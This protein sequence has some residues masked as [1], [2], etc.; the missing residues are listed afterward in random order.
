M[1]SAGLV[2]NPVG[3]NSMFY[4]YVLKSVKDGKMYTGA[5]SN[6]RERFKEHLNG[7]TASTKGRGP[8]KLIYY[9]ACEAKQDA[10]ARERYLKFGFG[11]RYLKNRLKRSLT[12][13]GFST[14]EVVI[15]MAIL[16]TILSAVMVVSWGNQTALADSR[17]QGEAL[18]RAQGILEC[19][20]AQA[21][22]DFKLVSANNLKQN[23]PELVADTFYTKTVDVTQADIEDYFGMIKQVTATVGWPAENNRNLN[24]KLSTLVA[25][26]ENVIGGDTCSSVLLGNWNN[27]YVSNSETDLGNLVGDSTGLYPITDLEVYKNSLFLTINN[28]A[29]NTAETFFAFDVTDPTNPTLLSKIDN[30]ASHSAGLAAVASDGQFAFVASARSIPGS[31][32]PTFGQLQ[33]INVSV[34]PVQL[35]R[36]FAIASVGGT[37]G[38]GI[39]KSIYYKDGYVYLGLTKTGSGPEFNIIDV[40]DPLNPFWVGGYSVG[41]AVNSIFVK[42]RYAYLATPNAEEFTVLDIGNITN[43]VRLGGFNG[44]S[45][46]DGQ[47]LAMVGDTIYLGRT[48]NSDQGELYLLNVANPALPIEQAY[49]DIGTGNQTSIK[50]LLVRDNLVFLATSDGLHIWNSD[51]PGSMSEIKYFS[52]PNSADTLDTSLDCENN[53]IFAGSA[54]TTG[55][56]DKRGALSIITTSP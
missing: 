32:D 40:H 2:G 10:W 34:N 46:A 56:N 4:T 33:I 49:Q 23:C 42:G 19:A 6:L 20:Q 8:Y 47:S 28:T 21:R 11:K 45:G 37:S 29:A 43:P 50:S 22:K 1:E 3:D 24:V 25:N 31:P 16:I 44:P 51:T 27:S 48:F 53:I 15:A 41:N 36:T 30:D 9:E 35:V 17:A 7:L 39:G 18:A 12:P 52:L 54:P 5:T 14:L 38:Q 13:T 26:F 55:I